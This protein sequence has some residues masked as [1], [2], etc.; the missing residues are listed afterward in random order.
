MCYVANVGDS[1][2]L[3]SENSSSDVFLLS[4]DHKPSDVDE[5]I[6]I[7]EGGGNIYQ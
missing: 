5:C 6:R 1:R 2:S 3:Y 4:K 7:E